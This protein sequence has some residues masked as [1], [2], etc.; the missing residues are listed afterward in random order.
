M[1]PAAPPATAAPKAGLAQHGLGTRQVAVGVEL[2]VDDQRLLQ[3]RAGPVCPALLGE[4]RAGILATSGQLERPAA[5]LATSSTAF[6]S[7]WS[8]R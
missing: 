3:Q 7:G 5:R 6:W 1:R 4:R 2:F 8:R